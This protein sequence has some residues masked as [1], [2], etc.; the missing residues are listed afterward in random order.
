MA[1]PDMPY[2]A[3]SKDRMVPTV[4]SRKERRDTKDAALKAAYKAVDRRDGGVCWV[5]GRPTVPNEPHPDYRREHHH[6]VTR[7]VAP[8][9]RDDPT[10]IVT[11]CKAAHDLITQGWIEVEGT[12]TERAVIFHWRTDIPKKRRPFVIQR[13]GAR[14]RGQ[15]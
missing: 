15:D 8:E 11:V 3:F 14:R 13:R 4:V 10:N 2:G 5:T 7:W 9:R 1:N 6:L 12:T